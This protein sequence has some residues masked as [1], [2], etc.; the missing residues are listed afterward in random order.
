MSKSKMVTI[1]GSEGICHIA[2][3]LNELIAIYPITPSSAIS[4]RADL[5]ASKGWKNLWGQVPT[6]IEM[7]SEGGAAGAVHGALQTGSLSTTFTSSQGLLL[8]IPNMYKIAG[9]LTSTVFHVA[10][11]SIAAQG[12]SIFNDHQDVMAVRQTGWAILG[13]NSV[14]EGMDMA[15]IAQA[16]TL[17]SRVPFVHF[18]DGF[19]TSHEISKV[20]FVGDDVLEAM[21]DSDLINAHRSRGLSPENPFIRG[22]AQNP[23]VYFQARETV[24][25]YYINVPG[26]VQAEMDKYGKLTGRNYK[27][28]EYYGAPDAD[29]VMVAMASA[30]E[31]ITEVVDALNAKGEK[32]GLLKVRLFRPFS[33]E[34]FVAALPKTVKNIVVLDKTKEPGS[35]GEPLYLD[36]VTTVTEM[37]AEGKAPFT[38]VP[39]ISGG[40]Y[41]LSSKEFNPGMIKGLFDAMSKNGPKN[42]FTIG[43][44][45]DVTFTSVAYDPSYTLEDADTVR[46]VFWGLGGDGTVSANKNSIKII[47][48]DTPN[49][50]QGYFVYDSKKA[51]AIT[52]SHLRF[53]KKPIRSPYLIT[54]ANF[55]ACHD[56]NF[57]QKY[58]VLKFAEQGATFLLNSPKPA[59]QVWDDMPK[60]VQQKLIDRK[61]KFYVMDAY[62]IAKDVGLGRRF[63]I[64]LQTG[65][66]VLSNVLPKDEAVKHIKEYIVKTWAKKGDDVVKMNIAAVDVS[67]DKLHEVK[68]PSAVSSTHT[69][70]AAVTANAPDFVQNVTAMMIR[71]DGD[72]L[73]VSAMPADGTYPSGTTQYE[74]RNIALEMPVWDEK[75]CI[76]CGKCVIICPHACIRGKV[77]DQTALS[78]APSEWL[79]AKTMF[80]QMWKDKLYTIQVAPEDCTGCTLCVQVCPAKSKTDPNHRAINMTPQPEIREREVKKWD[81]FDALPDIDTYSLP[82]N[83]VKNVQLRDPLFEFSGACAGCG[84]TPYLKLITQLYGERAIV[85]NATGCSSIYGG[86][87]PTTPWSKNSRGLGPAWS[88][89]LFEDGAEFGFGM[90]LS[91]Q[92]K[93]MYAKQLVT[94]LREQIGTELADAILNA[95]QSDDAKIELQRTRVTALHKTLEGKTDNKSK[96]LKNLADNLIKKSL[97]IVGGDGW[98][99]DIGYAGLDHVLASGENVNIM[100]MDTEVYSNTGG[101]ASKSTPFGAAAKFAAGGK[102]K[103]KKDLALIAMTYKNIYVAQVCMGSN[104]AQCLKAFQEAEQ[105]NGPSIIVAYSPCIEHGYDLS[106][107]VKQQKGAVDSAYWPLYRYDPRRIEQGKNPFQLD[108]KPPSLSLKDY[109]LGENRFSILTKGKDDAAV[110]AML[111]A[112][113]AVTE[114]WAFY[115]KMAKEEVKAPAIAGADNLPA[116]VPAG[117]K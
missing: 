46:A 71:G 61:I 87:L 44:N 43:I 51:G 101:Q 112:E 20:D 104:D 11:R 106:G 30:C 107:S 36:V 22:T 27:I 2:Y 53:G 110:A 7:Q 34:H 59:E 14:Q 70:Q 12:L 57:M 54:K 116:M 52:I 115:E 72:K 79:S 85:A 83:S 23:D 45:D 81:F 103:P 16:S 8:M 102:G 92:K 29:R 37:I 56:Y 86:N 75:L 60:E 117:A 3:K 9:E 62:T 66:F 84:E 35:A 77:Y 4:E 99:Y 105:F 95:D 50:A 82:M 91:Y 38:T 111:H 42:H 41:G 6:V 18:F 31:S 96:D 5:L 76:Q 108:S 1:D 100:I 55:V 17:K 24:N 39:R 89:S 40:R 74:K 32:V 80:G 13:S 49:H 97:W 113:K 69:M 114:R 10:A 48:E 63:N 88:N 73:P 19:R 68:I 58:D 47:G 15:V 21:M 25:Q 94:D 33:A 78:T 28:Y 90:T 26:I 65:F 109:L 93:L 67:L 98:A 64:P